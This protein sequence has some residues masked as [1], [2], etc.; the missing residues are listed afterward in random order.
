MLGAV[1]P[2][3]GYLLLGKVKAN[4]TD[5]YGVY[6]FN[7]DSRDIEDID[8]VRYIEWNP[9]SWWNNALS[10]FDGCIEHADSKSQLAYDIIREK[11]SDDEWK[12]KKWIVQK[13]Q[14]VADVSDATIKR[15][16]TELNVESRRTSETPSETEW[17]I[18]QSAHKRK[19]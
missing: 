11:L 5:E 9:E 12:C 4:V 10:E 19:Q 13:I 1:Q 18:P 14:S 2:P 16:A 7:I 15:V 8:D 3:D 6:P 17:R